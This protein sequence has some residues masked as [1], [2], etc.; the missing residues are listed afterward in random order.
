MKKIIYCA[1]ASILAFTFSNSISAQEAESNWYFT[2]KAGLAS[3]YLWAGYMYGGIS[4]V[5]YI[6]G[7]YS[8]SDDFTLFG[9]AALFTDFNTGIFLPGA[10]EYS[11][12]AMELDFGFSWKNFSLYLDDIIE[13]LY[14]SNKN[15][16][17]IGVCADWTLSR[18]YPLTLNWYSVISSP[19]DINQKG[20]QAFSTLV[21][22]SYTFPIGENFTLGPEVAVVPWD[23]PYCGYE[24]FSLCQI[25]AKGEYTIPLSDR[26]SLP[27]T[28]NA[29]WN[30]AGNCMYWMASLFVSFE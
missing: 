23:S 3:S 28:L 25:G 4:F 30:P 19:M 11:Y 22:A 7:G 2:G 27:I 24:N 9:D 15:A 1:I 26:L 21:N 16:H 20:K 17:Y 13:G 5:P 10:E 12:S 6:E 18:D 8:L 14:F 29:G